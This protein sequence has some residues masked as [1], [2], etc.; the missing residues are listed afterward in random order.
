M[1]KAKKEM[2]YITLRIPRVGILEDASIPDET[3]LS[4]DIFAA[5]DDG[6]AT[7]D[8]R[9][10]SRLYTGT[11]K[12]I[13]PIPEWKGYGLNFS[14]SNKCREAKRGGGGSNT[15]DV[16]AQLIAAGVLKPV[17]GAEVSDAG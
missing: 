12:S 2:T 9:D 14:V 7:V 6:F 1:A 4:P 10:D 17:N 16:I 11:P 5:R 15:A 13:V 8:K 3:T